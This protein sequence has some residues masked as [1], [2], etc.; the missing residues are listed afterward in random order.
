MSLLPIVYT[1]LLVVGGLL[2]MAIIISYFSFKI[3]GAPE[4]KPIRQSSLPNYYAQPAGYPSYNSYKEPVPQFAYQA[5]K[6]INTD[7]REYEDF[8]QKTPS[9]RRHDI[10]ISKVEM[11]DRNKMYR[12]NIQVLN[13]TK[14][15]PKF[16]SS[17]YSEDKLLT[18]YS[19]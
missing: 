4:Q 14:I 15:N 10:S 18:F 6:A 19:E 13:K 3:K 9:G 5:V 1:S 16:Y 17:D 12:T 11:Y 7:N 2:F 8:Y